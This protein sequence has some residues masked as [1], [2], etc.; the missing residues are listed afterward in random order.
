M[1]LTARVYLA[2]SKLLP[3]SF[4]ENK[5]NK[6]HDHSIIEGTRES[7][8]RM[9]M[10]YVDVIFAHRYDVTSKEIFF[11]VRELS[12]NDSFSKSLWRKSYVPSTGSSKKDG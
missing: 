2:N 6:H 9:G 12:L 11:L 1:G 3:T 10:E 8:E 4:Y 5:C 7:L